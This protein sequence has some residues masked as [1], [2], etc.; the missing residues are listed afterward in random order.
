MSLGGHGGRGI[1]ELEI[2]KRRDGG[3]KLGLVT[4]GSERPR[5]TS[6]HRKAVPMGRK[7]A[8]LCPLVRW[9]LE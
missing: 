1:D 9:R 5:P 7:E 2:Y 6:W 8:A 4:H 3:A